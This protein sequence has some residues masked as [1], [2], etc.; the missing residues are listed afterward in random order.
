MQHVRRAKSKHKRVTT[1]DKQNMPVA[2]YLAKQL[3]RKLR[4][5][6][7]GQH[8]KFFLETNTI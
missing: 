8:S 1:K 6:A 3:Q 2:A 5:V 7:F 4:A